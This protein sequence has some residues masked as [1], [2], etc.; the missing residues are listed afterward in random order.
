MDNVSPGFVQ[1][2]VP[3]AGA[4]GAKLPPEA[5]ASLSDRF[6]FVLQ[7]AFPMLRL[8]QVHLMHQRE[9]MGMRRKFL[10]SLDHR[11]VGVQ[12]AKVLPVPTVELA[13]L[14]IEDVDEDPDLGEHVGL[15][16]RQVVLR[17][18]VLASCK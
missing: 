1:G 4:V 11:V 15:L 17:K 16:G 10:Q 5:F 12:I 6:R 14:Y 7:D 2:L 8:D 9:D 13:R 3:D 18:G